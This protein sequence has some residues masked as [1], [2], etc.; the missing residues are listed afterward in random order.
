M[1]NSNR[2]AE[3]TSRGALYALH[4]DVGHDPSLIRPIAATDRSVVLIFSAALFVSALR[5]FLDQPMFAKMVLPL[6]GGSPSVW[7]TCVLFFQ[8][9]L[10]AG[11][12]YAHLVTT[13]LSIRWHATV[14]RR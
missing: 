9:S 12:A 6:L 11:Y 5:L 1:S 8:A 7:T 13:R 3:V 2:R 4:R 10:L 14:L